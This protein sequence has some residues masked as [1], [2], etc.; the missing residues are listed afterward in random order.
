MARTKDPKLEAERRARIADA[1][2]ELLAEGSWRGVTL[3]QVARRAGVSK[4]AVTYWFRGKDALFLEAIRRFHER[5]AET[6][7]RVAAEP[8]PVR[9]RLEALLEAAFPSQEAVRRELRFQT[10]VW[11]FAKTRPEVEAEIVQSYGH[12]RA[13]CEALLQLGVAEGYVRADRA[14]GLYR[15]I[16]ALI[17]GVS[18]QVAF[19]PAIDL[20]AT[21]RDLLALLERWFQAP[22]AKVP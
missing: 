8:R 20:H 5:Y 6:L 3:E 14:P 13:A 16:H 19:E 4:G 9:A 7:L 15:F 10:E 11:S 21:R 22:D 17:D 1:A 18:I 12:F 2:I